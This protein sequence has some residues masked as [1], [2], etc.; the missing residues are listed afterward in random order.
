MET[1]KEILKQ[2][3]QI[4]RGEYISSMPIIY[5]DAIIEAMESYRGQGHNFTPDEIRK[6]QETA[7]EAGFEAGKMNDTITL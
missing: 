7:Y 5:E 6:I 4:H 2:K 3:L 1:A